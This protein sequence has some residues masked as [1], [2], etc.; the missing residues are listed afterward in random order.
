M[1]FMTSAAPF[2]GGFGFNRWEAGDWDGTPVL[3]EFLD[4]RAA[5]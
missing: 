4:G 3:R 1:P 5:P 2:Y